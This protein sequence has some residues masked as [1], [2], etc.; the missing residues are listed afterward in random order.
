MSADLDALLALDDRWNAAY[1]HGDPGALEGVLAADWLGFLPDGTRL[2]RA[3]LIKHF[4]VSPAPT[5]MIERH[6]AR[7][8]GDAA[9]TR[10]TLYE[11][12]ARLQS[13]LRVYSRVDGHWQAVSAQ[14]VS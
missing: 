8:H 9:V 5:L 11:G 3:D 10:L 13:V 14:I 6:A 7:I 2:G 12:P 1:H 4:P